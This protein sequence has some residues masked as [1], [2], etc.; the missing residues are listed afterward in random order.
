MSGATSEVLAFLGGGFSSA[1]L[2]TV[3]GWSARKRQAKIDETERLSHI[4]GI[5]REEL[6]NENA[7][8]RKRMTDLVDAVAGLTDALDEVFPKM[9]GLSAEERIMLRQKINQARR[10]T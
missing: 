2:Q 4:A 10:A 1:V 7:D 3:V 8:L 9:S 5:I 6:R